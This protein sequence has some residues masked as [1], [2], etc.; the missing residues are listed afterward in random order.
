[1]RAYNFLEVG[2]ATLLEGDIGA[3]MKGQAWKFFGADDMPYLDQLLQGSLVT[4]FTNFAS[5]CPYLRAITTSKHT[6]AGP[7][8]LWHVLLSDKFLLTYFLFSFYMRSQILIEDHR[9]EGKNMEIEISGMHFVGKDFVAEDVE[10]VNNSFVELD[11]REG[12]NDGFPR[13]GANDSLLP[14]FFY[15]VVLNCL[16]WA[17]RS[18][19]ASLASINKRYNLLIRSRHL[20]ELRKKLGI[21]ELEHLVYLVCDPRGWEVFDPKR[22]RWIT[23]PKI[24]CDECFNLPEK[25]SLVV[26][27]EILVLDRELI[28]FSIWKYNLISCNWVKCKEMNS[29]RCLFGSGSLGSI[30]I[31]A[32]GTNKYGN[33]LEL[34]ELYDSN[35]GTW[36]LLPNMHTPRTLC[37][38]FFMDGKF[39]VIGGMSSPIV[40]LTCGEEYDLKTRNWRKIEVVDNQLYVVEH[41]S[42][43]VNKYDKERNTWSELGRLPIRA[44]SSNGWGLAFK[45]CGEKLLVVNGQRGPEGEAVVLN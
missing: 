19:Y 25:E 27:S 16:A 11:T 5:A 14:G 35:S 38:S 6:K 4:S 31:V 10:K 42:N 8:Q 39:Y 41:L 44:D 17:S 33:V 43:M 26:G 15:D 28:D 9:F 22:N 37:S 20:F 36:E 7:H 3:K 12:V 29:P 23:L 13:A 1:M 32:G 18:D 45:A 21:V 30:A 2:A 40:S 24:P 34:A